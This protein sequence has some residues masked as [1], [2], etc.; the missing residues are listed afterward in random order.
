MAYW[1][2]AYLVTGVLC[3]I[4]VARVT[5]C[6]FQRKYPLVAERDFAGDAMHACFQGM[7]TVPAWPLSMITV[8]FLSDRYKYG[9]R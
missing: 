1:L 3:G 5:F 8:Y 9:V 2:L 6:Y 4:F 7:L